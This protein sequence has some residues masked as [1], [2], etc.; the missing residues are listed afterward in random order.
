MEG[1]SLNQYIFNDREMVLKLK[2]IDAELNLIEG[3][4]LMDSDKQLLEQVLVNL[5]SNA[6][7]AANE[8][9]GKERGRIEISTTIDDSIIEIRIS[10]NGTGISE[11][12]QEKMYNLFFT[13]KPPGKG[14]GLGLPICQN[15][16]K[17]LGGSISFETEMGQG[18]TF[19]VRL[20]AE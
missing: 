9:E 12:D 8:K 6:V 16:I 2:G 5:I 13:T 7:Y 15:I 1:I 20:P 14:T 17:K 19:F 4:L 11:E 3:P 10:D 18:T